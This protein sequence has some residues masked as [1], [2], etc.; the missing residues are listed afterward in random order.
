MRIAHCVIH[1]LRTLPFQAGI[2]RVYNRI[3]RLAPRSQHP[4]STHLPVLAAMGIIVQPVQVLEYGSG[5]ISTPAF[6]NRAI[7]PSLKH[8][9]S[10]E[11]NREWH[12]NVTG[13]IGGDA[14]AQLWLTEG[15]MKDAVARDDL[16]SAD[17]VFVDDSDALGRAQTIAAIADSRPLGIP[18]VIH[19][20][21]L[22]QIRRSA[23]LFD[24]VF[25]FNAFH[26]QT[27]VAWNG[28][29]RPA[30]ALPLLNRLI[31]QGSLTVPCDD[32]EG[33][34]R[35][36]LGASEFSQGFHSKDLSV[37]TFG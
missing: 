1:L 31:R 9:A 27:G 10:F 20:M 29:W 13:R 18:I 23:A 8:I 2:R 25:C 15:P 16:A 11:N 14:R 35:A 30:R 5:L 34:V 19:D 3:I 24:H 6:L 22:L 17:L 12:E 32:V 36:F 37:T 21:E 28:H 33:W 4:Y 7:F 26:P